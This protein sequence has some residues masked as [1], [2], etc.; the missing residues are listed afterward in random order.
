MSKQE[1]QRAYA[2]EYLLPLLHRSGC[3]IDQE[4]VDLG[5][6]RG[7]ILN[8][9]AAVRPRTHFSGFERQPESVR[10][11][12]SDA[13]SASLSNVFFEVRDFTAGGFFGC[14]A[15]RDSGIRV[16]ITALMC[17]VA[18]H[19]T[20]FE[21]AVSEVSQEIPN[22]SALYVSFPPWTSPFGGHQHCCHWAF[23][24]LPWVHLVF[25]K[26]V[27]RAT[28]KS[29][30]EESMKIVL[31]SRLSSRQAVSVLENAGIK[32]VYK[33]KYFIR[34]EATRRGIR[35]IRA[36][37]WMPDLFVMGCEIIGRM[38]QW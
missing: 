9:M 5:S 1:A 28:E 8:A 30:D 36:P 2:V 29:T 11:A 14:P 15:A 31:R 19:L 17:D 24:Y 3:P 13:A 33:Q 32:V 16:P 6:G 37:W 35:P 21:K 18:E 20:D 23:R 25:K 38:A 34:P 7:G 27:W 4:V 10:I 12:R 22:G 26:A